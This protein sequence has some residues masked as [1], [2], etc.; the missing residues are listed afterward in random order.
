MTIIKCYKS[1]KIEVLPQWLPPIAWYFGG[2][3]IMKLF[4]NP[5]DLKMINKLK[6]KICLD[7]SHFILSCNYQKV[8][9]N[10]YINKYKGLFKHYHIADA[11]GVDGEGL[12]IGSGDL[13]KYKK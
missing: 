1:N 6:I 13:L 4:C 10:N 8:N 11:S 12:E 5:N 3:A 7:L 2:S 9:L